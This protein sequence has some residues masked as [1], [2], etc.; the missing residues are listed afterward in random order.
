MNLGQLSYLQKSRS[1][2]A[3]SYQRFKGNIYNGQVTRSSLLWAKGTANFLS[4]EIERDR[5]QH[6]GND[7]DQTSE[8]K[9][10]HTFFA[11]ND[12]PLSHL[13]ISSMY[14]QVVDEWV[15]FAVGEGGI[16]DET[17]NNAQW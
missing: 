5:G 8:R 17:L 1:V 4:G 6:G 7:L 13:L 9:R 14:E 16:A 2:G 15:V 12:R 11:W 3:A 10:S